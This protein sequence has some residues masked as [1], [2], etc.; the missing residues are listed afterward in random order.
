[1]SPSCVARTPLHECPNRGTQKYSLSADGKSWT[2]AGS[3]YGA[4]GGYSA[5][6]NRPD[7]QK[8]SSRREPAAVP[9]REPVQ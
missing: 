4:G 2:P 7:Y 9:L 1:M 6:F 3:L 8:G 5:L